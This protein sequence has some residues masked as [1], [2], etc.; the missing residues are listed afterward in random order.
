MQLGHI[1]NSIQSWQILSNL[2]MHPQTAYQVLKYF[3]LIAAEYEIAEK[4]RVALVHEITGTKD[5]ENAS[6]EPGTEQFIEYIT[7]FN[8]ILATE[9]DLPQYNGTLDDII[10]VIGKDQDN[11]LS[12]QDLSKLEVFFKP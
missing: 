9:S 10:A 6:I 7:R 3:K 4:Q 5:G 8:E 2:K 1:F 12:V 11:S